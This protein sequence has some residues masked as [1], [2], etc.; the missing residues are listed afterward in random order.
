MRVYYISSGLQG[1]YFLR[2]LLPLQA[3]GWDGDQTSILLSDRKP[4]DK[5]RAADSAD[6][7]VFHRPEEPNKLELAKL[8]K[9]KGKKIVFDNDDTV[10][11]DG[12]FRFNSIMDMERVKRGMEKIDKTIDNFIAIADLVTCSTEYLA[13]EY[14]KINKNVVVIPNCVDPFY[15]DDIKKNKSKVVRIGITGSLALTDDIDII[16]PIVRHFHKNTRVKIV[17]FSLPPNHKDTYTRNLYKEE[18]KFWESVDVEWQ[19]LV[20]MEEYFDTLNNLKLDLMIIPRADN[21]FNRCKSNVKFLE[22][23]MLEIPVIASGFPDGKSPYEVDPEDAE[24]LVLIKDV[25]DW[26]PKIEEMIVDKKKRVALG[27]KARKYV[28]EKYNI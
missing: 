24:N 20:P 7:I 3:N 10:K 6:I 28:E 26:I 15:F 19:P 13:E 4:E 2:C 27:K 12:G 16:E 11:H 14:R 9:Q 22:A 18:Y 25:K 21:Y 23:S 5:S 17:L 8:L 1:C